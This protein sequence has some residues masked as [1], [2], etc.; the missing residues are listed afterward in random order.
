MAPKPSYAVNYIPALQQEGLSA[1]AAL[2]R[3][4]DMGLGVRRQTFLRAWGETR[5]A[6]DRSGAVQ[7]APLDRAPIGGEITV[8]GRPRARGYLYNVNVAV[9]DPVTKEVYFTPWGVR[10]AELLTYG[11]AL[12]QAVESF[13]GAAD[14]GRG[15]PEGRALGATVEDVLQLVPEDDLLGVG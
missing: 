7:T 1:N 6:A 8:A 12:A 10:S 3:L 11:A 13:A 9:E 5:A 4:R 15:T 2:Q 14:F